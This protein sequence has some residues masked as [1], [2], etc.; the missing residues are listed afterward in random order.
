MSLVLELPS[1]L[2]AELTS[3]AAREG[4]PLAEY[5][6]RLLVAARQSQVS[7]ATG[8]NL[9]AYWRAEGLVGARNDIVDP[10]EHARQVRQQAEQRN[11]P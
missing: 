7:P 8:V 2:E 3:E 5:T 9:V 11:R 6:L 1:A 4:V 10:A